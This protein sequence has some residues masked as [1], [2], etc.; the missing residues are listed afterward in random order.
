MAADVEMASNL[1]E[2]RGGASGGLEGATMAA[3][4]GCRTS[5]FFNLFDVNVSDG[6]VLGV[7][8]C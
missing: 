2:M 3:D 1:V 5:R 6:C 8:G 4:S 7:S